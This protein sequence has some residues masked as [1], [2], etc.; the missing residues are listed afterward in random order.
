MGSSPPGIACP[1]SSE[2]VELVQQ[3]Y[4]TQEAL[5]RN[6]TV[7]EPAVRFEAPPVPNVSTRT[8]NPS[9]RATRHPDPSQVLVEMAALEGELHVMS[10]AHIEQRAACVSALARGR[11]ARAL[12]FT[13]MQAQAQARLGSTVKWAVAIAAA[14]ML[15]CVRR[16]TRPSRRR[17]SSM[18]RGTHAWRARRSLLGNRVEALSEQHDLLLRSTQACERRRITRCVR[19]MPPPGDPTLSAVPAHVGCCL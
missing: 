7:D 11:W 3:L 2:L 16:L 4:E 12:A 17:R 18:P 6:H 15:T 14:P 5:V 13:S 10:R 1:R 9:P 19:E 8:Q